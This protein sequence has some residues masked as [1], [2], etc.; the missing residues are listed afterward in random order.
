MTH[1]LESSRRAESIQVI[2]FFVAL[3]DKE[4]MPFY[5]ISLNIQ[6]EVT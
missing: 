4:I 3:N 1:T 6:I 5:L 2:S